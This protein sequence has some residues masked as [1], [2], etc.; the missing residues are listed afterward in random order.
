MNVNMSIV[1]NFM[2]KSTSCGDISDITIINIKLN[3]RIV[4]K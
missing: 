2:E 3:E 4:I 1:F